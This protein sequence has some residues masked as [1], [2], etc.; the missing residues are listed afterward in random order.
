[1]DKNIF[2]N[3]S[4]SGSLDDGHFELL[5]TNIECKELNNNSSIDQLTK[6]GPLRYKNSCVTDVWQE[7]WNML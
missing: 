5:E 6:N 3:D 2:G 4:L 7:R 1:M